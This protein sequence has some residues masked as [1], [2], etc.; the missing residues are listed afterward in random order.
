MSIN[1]HGPSLKNLR[2][3][4]E[5]IENRS[6]NLSPIINHH[7]KELYAKSIIKHHKKMFLK[8]FPI[9]FLISGDRTKVA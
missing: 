5:N 4:M 6:S 7:S 9:T 3:Y 8:D 1:L 2:K